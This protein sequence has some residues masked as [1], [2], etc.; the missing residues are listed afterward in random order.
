[1]VEMYV[2]QF[3]R[4]RWF[5]S[6]SYT[7]EPSKIIADMKPEY[8][9]RAAAAVNELAELSAR[10]P[11]FRANFRIFDR[12]YDSRNSDDVTELLERL[13]RIKQEDG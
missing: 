1:M 12:V 4:N 9:D 8:I 5:G 13:D 10:C 2:G 6:C 7:L 11:D 3:F